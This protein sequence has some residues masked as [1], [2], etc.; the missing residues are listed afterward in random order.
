M[1]TYY[2]IE[3]RS[4]TP[5]QRGTDAY[6]NGAEFLIANFA[7]DD[8]K[9]QLWDRI[10]GQPIPPDL[11]DAFRDPNEIFI[12]H[13]AS[14]DRGGTARLTGIEIPVSRWR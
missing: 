10:N 1:T 5:I 6:F 13:H 4:P 12:A 3:S 7:R 2:D 9:P 14:F 11:E 8:G